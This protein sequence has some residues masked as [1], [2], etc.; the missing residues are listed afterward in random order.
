MGSTLRG[1]SRWHVA[2]S[3]DFPMVPEF[4]FGRDT[5]K[6]VVVGIGAYRQYRPLHEI[7]ICVF[8]YS[9]WLAGV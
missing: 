2:F 7:A 6:Q 8:G 9:P 4:G 1:L 3:H 5:L